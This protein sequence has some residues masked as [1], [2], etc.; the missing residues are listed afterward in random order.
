MNKTET[1]SPPISARASGA[2]DSLPSPSFSAIGSRP[3]IV[4]SDVISTGRS[5]TRQAVATASTGSHPFAPQVMREL[6]NQ[7]A[8]RHRD[9]GEHHHAHQRHHVQRRAGQPQRQQHAGEPRRKCQQDDERIDEGAELRD[10]NQIQQQQRKRQPMAKLRNEE[11]IASTIPRTVTS[12]PA[13][14]F[15][16]ASSASI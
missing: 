1:L 6:D 14:S 2:Y 16:R 8:V 4:A 5:R 15:V 9:P 7:N 11:R 13:G 3:M 12:T 10:Q